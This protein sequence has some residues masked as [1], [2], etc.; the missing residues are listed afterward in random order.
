[1]KVNSIQ[2]INFEQ[3]L[4]SAD[5][6]ISTEDQSSY[7]ARIHQIDVLLD[8]LKSGKTTHTDT[9]YFYQPDSII[10]D[11]INEDYMFDMV[12]CLLDDGDFHNVFKKV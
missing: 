9:N 12:N 1:M 7:V 2:L 11:E 4:K 5:I 8:K 6:I 10:V 3:D